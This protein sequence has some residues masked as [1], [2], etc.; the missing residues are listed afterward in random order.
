MSRPN[1]INDESKA[2]LALR[3]A[4]QHTQARA[5]KL[6]GVATN[7]FSD[8]ERGEQCVPVGFVDRYRRA[9][10]ESATEVK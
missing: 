4:A 10:A 3:R 5:A 8:Y 9:L 7:L 6:V 2:L 1:P